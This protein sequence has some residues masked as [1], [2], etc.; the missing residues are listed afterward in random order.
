MA[1]DTLSGYCL[2]CM[3]SDQA[4][5][6][7]ILSMEE[8]G[9]ATL[10]GFT[11]SDLFVDS[12]VALPLISKD[13]NLSTEVNQ[14]L[15]VQLSVDANLNLLQQLLSFIHLSA[16]FKLE[17]NRTVNVKLLSPKKNVVNDFK[18]DAY[19]NSARADDSSTTY[20]GMLKKNQLYVVTDILKCKKYTLEYTN[21]NSF[22]TNVDAKAPAQGDASAGIHAASSASD[23]VSND[24][25]DFITIG[26]IAYQI[27]Y[28]QD[29]ITG[30]DRYRIRKDEKLKTVKGIEGGESFAGEKLQATQILAPNQK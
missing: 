6:L 8:K 10:R 17:K 21:S 2:V 12:E 23:N 4:Q 22:D 27:L 20:T 28:Y 5:P 13:Y 25:D 30:K 1:G 15:E 29:N 14:S 26:V 16:S 19:I 11:I 3:P 24:G 9:I 7:C 18:L